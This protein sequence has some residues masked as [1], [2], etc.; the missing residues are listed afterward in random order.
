MDIKDADLLRDNV[1]W[2]RDRMPSALNNWQST[3][4]DCEY[5]SGLI[6]DICYK[7]GILL[8]QVFEPLIKWLSDYILSREGKIMYQDLDN[9]LRAGLYRI[10]RFVTVMD[11]F[12]MNTSYFVPNAREVKSRNN[13]QEFIDTL[14][15]KLIG[16]N[17]D[18]AFVF[19]KLIGTV[20]LNS[21]LQNMQNYLQNECSTIR[22]RALKR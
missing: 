21:D 4:P 14:I 13:Y 3:K 20:K 12:A 18:L 22:I 9:F 17:Q 5:N 19:L 1:I 6:K 8:P 16:C 2:L 11:Y 7:P 10:F 15:S